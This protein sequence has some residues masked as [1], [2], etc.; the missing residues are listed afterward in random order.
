VLSLNLASETDAK[1]IAR[2]LNE[3]TGVIP[4]ILLLQEVAKVRGAERSVAE[5]LARL[6]GFDAVFA[7]PRAGATTIGLAILSRW[8]LSDKDVRKVQSFY[9][10][11]K[12]R[13]RLALAATVHSPSGPI[14]VWTTHLDTRISVRERLEQLRPL[15]AEA[16][17]FQGP[18]IFGG[19]LNTNRAR[20]FLH[21]VP[22]PAGNVHSRAVADLMRQ[23]GFSTPFSEGR[24]TFDL[25]KLQLDWVYLRGLS[26]A[27]TGIEPL[28]FSDHHAIWAEFAT[29]GGS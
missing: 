4:D 16:G 17:R 20:W 14:R 1:R 13:P 27:A 12:F 18:C 11:L 5:D 28:A 19:D 23:H 10:L 3:R 26:T 6:L 25:F 22:F 24:P 2:E 9:R 15:L 21:A 8:L 29:P 7:S